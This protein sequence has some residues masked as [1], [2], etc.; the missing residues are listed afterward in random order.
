MNT[1]QLAGAC[2]MTGIR[3][4]SLDDPN[5]RADVDLLKARHVKGVIL[6]STHLPTGGMRNIVS[7]NQIQQ[8]TQDLRNE[9]GSDLLIGIDQEG[10][11][12]NRL[13]IFQDAGVSSMLSA[14]MQGS[15]GKAQIHA[16]I[17]TVARSLA[18]SGINLVFAPCVDLEI[19]PNNPIIAQ[20]GRSLGRDP[21]RVASAAAS[22]IDAYHSLGVRCCIKHFPGHGSSTTDTHLGIADITHTQHADEQRV[23]ELLIESMRSG[24]TPNAAVMT[25]HLVHQSIDSLPAS[26]SHAHITTLLREKLGFDGLVFTDSIDMGAVRQHH[27]AGAAAVLALHAGAD[28]V[29][30]GFNAPDEASHHPSILIHDAIIRSLELGEIDESMLAASSERRSAFLDGDTDNLA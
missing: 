12:V 29:L 23:Y 7:E 16:T 15:M 8:F 22:I 17:S 18:A 11:S 4:A 20:K 25:G 27:D 10:G 1:N 26:L 5:C 28:I 13:E 2:I 6:F 14:K 21:E 9:L 24:T 30:D 19:N 3:G